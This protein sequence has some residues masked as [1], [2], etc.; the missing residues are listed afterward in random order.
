MFSG[1]GNLFIDQVS[2]QGLG[3]SR[4]SVAQYYLKTS[5]NN[6]NFN[7]VLVPGGNRIMVTTKLMKY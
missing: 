4:R 5:T 2:V 7:V 3:N 1:L 6:I